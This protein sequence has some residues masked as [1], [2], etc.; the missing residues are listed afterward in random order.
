M[1]VHLL[2]SIAITLI[3]AGIDWLIGRAWKRG[4]GA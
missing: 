4:Q 3:L 1:G 2:A